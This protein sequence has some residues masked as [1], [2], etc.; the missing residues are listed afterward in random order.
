MSQFDK[1][2]TVA[3]A[4]AMLPE[5]RELLS[6]LSADRDRLVVEWEKAAPVLQLAHTNGGGKETNEYLSGLFRINA[7]LRRLADLGV[8]LKDIDTGLVDFPAW[9][10]GEEVLLCWR[11]GEAEVGFWHDLE[12]G[13]RGRRPL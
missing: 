6:V 7:R 11:L 13:F 8:Q 2:F 3:E 12:S 9:R 10:E 5:L 1:H 4:N